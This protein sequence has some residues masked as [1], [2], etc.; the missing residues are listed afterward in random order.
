MLKKRSGIVDLLIFFDVDGVLNTTNS[1]ITKY[2]I[3]ND[4][5]VAFGLLKDKLEKRGYSVKVVLSST[6]RLGYESDFD[7]CSKQVQELIIKLKKV[8]LAIYDKTP[9]YK[10]QTRD[11]EIKR[12]IK[13]YIKTYEYI[14][15]ENMI[16]DADVEYIVLDDDTSIFNEIALKKMNFY[17]VSERTGLTVKDAEK[18]AKMFR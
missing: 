12:Y 5:V 17:K 7:R 15:T 8:G 18:I 16:L 11:V 14:D 2:E 3:K 13:G 4:N 10:E 9:Y 1:R 6:W